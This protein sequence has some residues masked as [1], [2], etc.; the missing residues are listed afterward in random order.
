MASMTPAE[1]RAA[2][3]TLGLGVNEFARMCGMEDARRARKWLDADD[4]GPSPIAAAFLR[5]MIA[6]EVGDMRTAVERLVGILSRRGVFAPEVQIEVDR[7]FDKVR[8]GEL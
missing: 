6:A 5:Y 4:E 1:Y 7:A 3:E 2:L 8:R